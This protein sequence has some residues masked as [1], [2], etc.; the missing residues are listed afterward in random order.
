MFFGSQAHVHY[1]NIV[2]CYMTTHVLQGVIFLVFIND[3]PKCSM[4]DSFGHA[5]DFKIVG[6][7]PVAINIDI[8]RIWKWCQSNL[9]EIN[10][11][12]SKCLWLKGVGTVRLPNERPRSS[13]SRQSY[14]GHSFS[15][16][17]L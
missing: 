10:L 2:T 15:L 4:S 12:K 3:L 5:D 11:S 16:K 8:W 6:T 13:C 7:N 14:M 17:R 1:F 9:I